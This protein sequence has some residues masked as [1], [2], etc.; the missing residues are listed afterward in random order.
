MKIAIAQLDFTVGDFDH[1]KIKILNVYD[2]AVRNGAELIVYPELAITGYPPKDLLLKHG[3]VKE[4]RTKFNEI[5]PHI[6]KAAAIIGFVEENKK[7][8]KLFFNSAAFIRYGSILKIARKILIPSYDV[9]DED[10]YFEP[11]K[12]SLVLAYLKNRI[13]ISICEDIWND[14]DYPRI[15]R[16]RRDPINEQ[17]RQGAHILI[18]ISS[19]PY[20][21]GKQ[22]LR[23]DM[24]SAIARKHKSTVIY[25]NLVGANDELIF[26][27][28][29]YVI[30]EKG[31][32][33][34]RGKS[35]Q[36]DIVYADVSKKTGMIRDPLT[37]DAEALYHALIIGVKD[38]IHKCGFKDVVIGLSGGIDS[39]IVA[40]IA[41]EALGPSHVMGVAMPSRY[42]SEASITDAQM[43]AKNL[44]IEFMVIDIDSIY[45]CY[46]NTL[47]K[48]F[49][50]LPQDTTEQNIQARIRGNI[51]MAIS[52]K[53]NR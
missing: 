31:N 24:L 21:L 13:G 5:V 30:D 18:N 2:E 50:D 43:L 23:F 37:E 25:C 26:D 39:A 36:E 10:R 40:C 17:T 14:K 44:S 52:N 45:Q 42:S 1:N 53:Y 28:C 46:L 6:Q 27:G 49:K 41:A 47:N 3:F 7:S 15:S 19:S 33:I 16:Y 11:G 29:S 51:L 8:G 48:L 35:F 32:L 4:S 20:Y 12:K 38:Y 22:S 9:F 34:A